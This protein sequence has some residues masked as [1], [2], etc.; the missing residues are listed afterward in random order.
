MNDLTLLTDQFP[1]LQQLDEVGLA[2]L[3]R[4]QRVQL[5]ADQVVF[6]QGSACTHFIIV[7]SGVVKVLGRNANGREL[8]L[9][10]I[11]NQGSC[12]L[13]TSCLLGAEDYPAEGITETEVTAF[14]IPL[15]EF[16]RA[17]AESEGLRRFIFDSY[18]ERLA[19][20]I[21]L[22]QEIAFERIEKR[23]ARYLIEHV[24]PG[25]V[26]LRSHQ[27]IADELG[28]AREVVSRQLKQFEQK[29]WVAL[30]RNQVL[31]LNKSAV[32]RAAKES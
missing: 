8:V 11:E 24:G 3:S 12:V 20:L 23:L 16:Q 22:V 29:E 6:H 9:Y 14:L 2:I 10:R 17:I 4:A 30:S 15:S 27:E 1:L 19:K 31:F 25:F 18:G 21:G 26:L 13:T 28:T 5:P 32:K 7:V